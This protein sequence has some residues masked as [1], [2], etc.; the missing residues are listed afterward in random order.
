MSSVSQ[1]A[2]GK[3]EFVHN[4]HLRKLNQPAFEWQSSQG[5]SKEEKSEDN[6][7]ETS[8][9]KKLSTCRN[10]VQ[11]KIWIADDRGYVCKRSHLQSNGCCDSSNISLKYSCRECKNSTGCCATFEFCVS[12]CMNPVNVRN[13]CHILASLLFL[14]MMFFLMS[15]QKEELMQIL[16]EASALSNLLLLSV[17][18]QFELCLAKCRTSSRSVQHENLYIDPH[19]K[20]CYSRGPALTTVANQQQP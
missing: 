14:M 15:P 3:D 20:Y 1:S 5:S 18:D 13:L 17:S 11:G 2:I 8:T 19:M 10:S 6:N 12:C 16:N 9:K 7:Q 4:V